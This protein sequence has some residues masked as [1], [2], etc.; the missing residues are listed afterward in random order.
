[1]QLFSSSDGFRGTELFVSLSDPGRYLTVAGIARPSLEGLTSPNRIVQEGLTNALKHADA[2][3]A[4]VTVRYRPNELEIEVRDNGEGTV[5]AFC[6]RTAA[7]PGCASR[8][9]ST[10]WPTSP[11]ASVRRGRRCDRADVWRA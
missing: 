1:V 8:S 10:S 6:S 4:D 9:A 2:S 7:R 5:P 11:L 3:D